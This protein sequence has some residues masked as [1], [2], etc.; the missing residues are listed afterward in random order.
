MSEWMK[1]PW[2]EDEEEV[3]TRTGLLLF[4]G[5]TTAFLHSIELGLRLQG[6]SGLA[7]IAALVGWIPSGV[8]V[9]VA[10]I[11][12]S[13]LGILTGNL[14]W[15]NS[16]FHELSRADFRISILLLCLTYWPA[17]RLLD[18]AR[19]VEAGKQNKLLRIL[20]VASLLSIFRL[21]Q[22]LET[23]VTQ[24]LF[25]YFIAFFFYFGTTIHNQDEEEPLAPRWKKRF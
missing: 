25:L 21:F 3:E 12:A 9:A 8:V 19:K 10:W 7:I 20:E 6:A 1:G 4:V 13:L 18:K 17:K 16:L 5:A 2:F 22:I 15:A 24:R 23:H 14:V 11:L